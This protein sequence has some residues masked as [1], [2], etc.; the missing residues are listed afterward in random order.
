M[1]LI[2][3]HYLQNYTIFLL[4]FLHYKI[5]FKQHRRTSGVVLH[6]YIAA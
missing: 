6:V 3:Y 1:F 2:N 5:S 4:K